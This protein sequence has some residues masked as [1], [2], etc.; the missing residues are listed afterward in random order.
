MTPAELAT[1]VFSVILVLVILFSTILVYRITRVDK[2][3]KNVIN[4]VSNLVKEDIYAGKA[5]AWRYR[6]VDKLIEKFNYVVFSFK[7]LDAKNFCEDTSF[8]E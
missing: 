5:W 7:K 6:E 8:L 3:F 4:T 2:W 1:L